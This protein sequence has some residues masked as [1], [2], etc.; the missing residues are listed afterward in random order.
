M[1]FLGEGLPVYNERHYFQHSGVV[2]S[3]MF[4]IH[5]SQFVVD[6]LCRH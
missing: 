3:L 2:S 4:M 5:Y 1:L 6:S